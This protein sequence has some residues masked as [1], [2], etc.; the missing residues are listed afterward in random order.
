MN[1]DHT[2]FIIIREQ[3]IGSNSMNSP[4]KKSSGNESGEKQLEKLADSAESATN[5]FRDRFEE[6]IHQETLQ[7]PTNTGTTG[8]V[9]IRKISHVCHRSKSSSREEGQSV[10]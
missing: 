4:T 7:S 1:S 6:F 5:K 8:N 9:S 10:E 2:H 3:P